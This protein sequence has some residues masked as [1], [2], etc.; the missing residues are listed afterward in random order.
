MT[1]HQGRE[2]PVPADLVYSYFEGDIPCTM[3]IANEHGCK[4][5]ATHLIRMVHRD[6]QTRMCGPESLEW[7][8][9][10]GEHKA[11]MERTVSGF[12]AALLG[13]VPCVACNKPVELASVKP[14]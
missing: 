8:P 2:Q 7:L 5:K 3:E 11:L 13:T 6:D 12:W 1:E 4:V 10:C 9:F 14:L